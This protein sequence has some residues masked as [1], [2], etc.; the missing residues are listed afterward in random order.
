MQRDVGQLMSEGTRQIAGVG[1]QDDGPPAGKC[2]TRSPTGEPPPRVVA[3]RLGIRGDD[4]ANLAKVARA[5]AGPDR[6]SIGDVGEAHRQRG[7]C[8]PRDGG[9]PPHRD[10][11]R[12]ALPERQRKN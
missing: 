5:E 1:A 11:G 12:L 9:D 2:G 10:R 7:L 3:K 6:G 8:R 4:Q